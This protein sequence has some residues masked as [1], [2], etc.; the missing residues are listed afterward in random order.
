MA[1]RLWPPDSGH[2]AGPCAVAGP[3]HMSSVLP[4]VSS[5]M[6]QRRLPD[7]IARQHGVWVSWGCALGVGG[8]SRW[9][10]AVPAAL[11]NDAPKSDEPKSD[12]PKSDEEAR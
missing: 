2:I 5:V 9:Q 6:P 4:R 8:D 11:G 3:P 7:R 10:P 1:R 12:E